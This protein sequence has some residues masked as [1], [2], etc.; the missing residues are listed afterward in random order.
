MPAKS[1]TARKSPA[2]S[3]A[4]TESPRWRDLLQQAVEQPGLI[5]SC[6]SAFHNYSIGNQLLAYSQCIARGITPGPMTTYNGWLDKGRHVKRGEKALALY[7]PIVVKDREGDDDRRTIFVLRN[8]WFVLA[9]TDGDPLPTPEVP[10]WNRDKALADLDV[11]LVD[12]TDVN[13]NCQGY[14]FGRKVAVNPLAVHPVKTLVHEMAHVL[15][16]HTGEGGRMVD[17]ETLSQGIVE[18]EAEAVALLVTDALGVAGETA[19]SRGYIQHWLNGQQLSEAHVRRIFRV[20][21]QVLAA[22]RE[23]GA[24]VETEAE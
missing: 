8:R 13:G 21:D 17:G 19:Y 22:G 18:A 1:S 24:D 10:G 14:A 5:H 6:Y 11:S 2:P 9:Q 3:S 23:T 15:L 7:Q 4:K 20:A 16:G 12:Y